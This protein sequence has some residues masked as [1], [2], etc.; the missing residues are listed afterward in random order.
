MIRNVGGL[1]CSGNVNGA[2][3][4]IIDRDNLTLMKIRSGVFSLEFGL[5]RRFAFGNKESR[6]AFIAY[7]KSSRLDSPRYDVPKIQ[8][9]RYNKTMLTGLQAKFG[10]RRSSST[11]SEQHIL[12]TA[13][14][15]D[16]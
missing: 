3:G 4:T 7:S 15:P 6:A 16:L 12:A 2:K 14:A 9:I 5:N 13:V 8:G 11:R 10:D 1:G